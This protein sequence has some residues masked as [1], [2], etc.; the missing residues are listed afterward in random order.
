MAATTRSEGQSETKARRRQEDRSAAMRARLIAATID[1]L[2]E[3]G[4]A[5]TNTVEICKRAGVT[6][7][8]LLHHFSGL[9]DVLAAAMAQI[10][11]GLIVTHNSEDRV[12][13]FSEWIDQSWAVVSRPEFKAVIEIWLAARNDP[14]LDPGVLREITRYKHLFT[15]E[16]NP[17]LAKRLGN[18]RQTVSYY[19]LCVEAMIGMAL[20]RAT[21]PGHKPLE[22]E[23]LVIDQLKA[24]APR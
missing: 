8:A 4:Y 6:R 20:G 10:Y 24:A 17:A 11:D 3:R 22:H 15:P 13:S 14:A 2:V 21:S 12:E 16:D 23:T 5:G 7:G 1:S 19:R 18:T 9:G